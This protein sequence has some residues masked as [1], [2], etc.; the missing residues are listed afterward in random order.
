[1][2]IVLPDI[3][4]ETQSAFIKRRYI[5]DNILICQ[6]LVRL[7]KR[8]SCSPRC[9]MKTDLKKAYDSIEWAFIEQML[10]ALQFPEKMIRG[11]KESIT[12]ILRDFVTFSVAS[13]LEMNNDKSEIYFN[14][15][16]EAEVGYVLR[17]SG[18][19]ET[20]FPFRYLGIPISY[21][22]MVVG[23]CTRL[24]E[25]VVGRIRGWVSKKLSYAGRLVPVQ[26]VLSQLHTFGPE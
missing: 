8:K 11:D 1:M 22:R 7:Y 19:K 18:F 14:G 20:Q 9:I 2:A 15:M 13:G 17:I 25:K 10:S 24:V 6:D 16:G 4:S 12:I 23:D 26:A 21:T 3:I 5:V